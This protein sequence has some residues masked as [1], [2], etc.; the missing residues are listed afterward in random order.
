MSSSQTFGGVCWTSWF[1]PSVLHD[2]GHKWSPLIEV[3]QTENGLSLCW[4][5]VMLAVGRYTFYDGVVAEN[6]LVDYNLG[7]FIQFIDLF[8]A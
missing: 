6:G 3:K 1:G 4:L 8:C 2:Y 7:C 5:V